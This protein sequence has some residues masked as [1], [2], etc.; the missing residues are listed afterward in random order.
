MKQFRLLILTNHTGHSKENSLYALA[1]A[2]AAHPCSLQVDV[3]SRG[4]KEN[5]AFFLDH[6]KNIEQITTTKV[7]DNFCFSEGGSYFLAN[8]QKTNL[9][10]Y[11]L[12]WLRMPPP[13]TPEFLTFLENRFPKQMIIN[14]PKGIYEAGSKAFLVN[15]A[16]CCPPMKICESVEDIVAFKKEFPIVLKPFQEYG[17][18]GIVKIKGDSVWEGNDEMT[19]DEFLN[20]IDTN[21]IAYLGVKFLENVSKGDKRIVVVNGKILGASLRLPP[22]D[23][24]ICNVAMGGKPKHSEVDEDEIKMIEMINPILSERGIVMY[25]VDTLVGDDGKR[26]LSEINTTSIGGLPQMEKFTDKP[27]VEEAADLIW[28]YY[29]DKTG[30][31]C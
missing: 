19:F 23:S 26:V 2:M 15:F 6:D 7:N 1:K 14:S 10:D 25:G 8:S 3:A 12:I 5:D 30:N 13:L 18:K 24:W 17:G 11:D 27:L 21:S 28:N 9:S 4:I 16:D 31:L 29:M 22:K 20:K